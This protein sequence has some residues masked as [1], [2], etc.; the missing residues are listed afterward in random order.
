MELRA[1]AVNAHVDRPAPFSGARSHD[2]TQQ[3]RQ[4]HTEKPDLDDV[5]RKS[6]AA[7]AHLVHERDRQRREPLGAMRAF[8][9]HYGVKLA[10]AEPAVPFLA[11][12]SLD[13]TD[14]NGR[15]PRRGRKP[16]DDANEPAQRIGPAHD[17][18]RP[19]G[20]LPSL[21]AVD[22]SHRPGHVVETGTE[23]VAKQNAG[24]HLTFLSPRHVA[25]HV[26]RGLPF[27]IRHYVGSPRSKG[28]GLTLD[29]TDVDRQFEMRR[30][31][32]HPYR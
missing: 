7:S 11:I 13:E 25:S 10:A 3:A 12:R 30:R 26:Y 5:E 6:P 19:S 16:S 8:L 29:L 9:R 4:R 20:V 31:P 24:H 18:G 21:D 23:N 15:P 2:R 28:Q 32:P 22:A 1:A 17:A 27:A 14:M